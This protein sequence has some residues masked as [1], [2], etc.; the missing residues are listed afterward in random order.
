MKK[1]HYYYFLL[2]VHLQKYFLIQQSFDLDCTW[3]IENSFVKHKSFCILQT[4]VLNV[5]TAVFTLVEN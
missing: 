4:L 2:L 3:Q 1:C 5:F